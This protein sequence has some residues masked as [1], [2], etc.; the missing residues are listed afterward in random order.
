MIQRIQSLWLLVAVALAGVML[1]YPVSHF[2]DGINFPKELNADNWKNFLY[3]AMFALNVLAL[4][5][6]AIA[7]FMFKNRKTQMKLIRWSQLFLLLFIINIIAGFFWFK[8]S[9]F[10]QGFVPET[11]LNGTKNYLL[12]FRGMVLPFMI[13]IYNRLGF[14]GVKADDK[15]IRSRDRLR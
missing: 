11:A 13:L 3:V 10:P 8:T 15:L 6:S 2:Y 1:F 9:Y 7:I 14:A 4:V 5:F 12:E